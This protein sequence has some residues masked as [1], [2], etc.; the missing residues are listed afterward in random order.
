MTLTADATRLSEDLV[1]LRHALHREPE[2]GLDLPR[3]QEKVLAALDGLPL[4]ISTGKGLSSVTAVLR[5]GAAGPD[6]E[7]E[8]VLLRGDMDALPVTERS[9]VPY[10]SE[11]EAAMHACG[12]DLH[13]AM[14]VGAARLLAA[15]RASL[16]GDVV[17]MFQPG[18]EGRRGAKLMIDEG[19]LEASGRRPVAAYALHVTSSMLPYGWFATRPGPIMAA[20]DVFDVTVRG[21]GG[22]GSQPHLA[23]DPVPAA[24]E[25]VLALQSFV[26]R[27]FDV[28]DP[29]VLTVGSFHAGTA[30]NVIPD[31]VRFSATMRSFSEA[32]HARVREGAVS[33]VR[34]VAAAHGLRVDTGFSMD[35]PVTVND[36]AEAGRVADVVGRSYGADRFVRLPNPLA[37]AEDFSYVLGEVPGAFV[38]LG[39]CPPGRDPATAPFN[40]SA[41]AVFDDGVLADGAALL[42]SLALDRLPVTR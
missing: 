15:R 34:G 38:F 13:T 19:V 9:G 37:T 35:Y 17:F 36:A 14:L 6:G 10:G 5:G 16:T 28:F 3:T 31:E 40:H 18:E 4:E 8:T 1:R 26:T 20:A 32:S 24:C 7:T 21:E 33:V 42:A 27:S 41:E 39:A 25:M 11:T 2:T 23:H 29:V 30:E 12:H 22:H